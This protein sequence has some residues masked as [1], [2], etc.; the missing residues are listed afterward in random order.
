MKKHSS[1]A[2]VALIQP[3]SNNKS[4]NQHL[5]YPPANKTSH[6]VKM[7]RIKDKEKRSAAIQK[8]AR[9]YN[10]F[11]TSLEVRSALPSLYGFSLW[12]TEHKEELSYSVIK[13]NIKR[14]NLLTEAQEIFIWENLIYQIVEKKSSTVKETLIGLLVANDFLKEV[15]DF[16][17]KNDGY[18]EDIVFTEEQHQRFTAIAHATVVIT[19]ELL[20]AET[21]TSVATIKDQKQQ[22]LLE[23]C[24][25]IQNKIELYKQVIT[26]LKKINTVYDSDCDTRF[27]KALEQQTETVTILADDLLSE[28]GPIV[29]VCTEEEVDKQIRIPPF[30]V[31]VK[32]P[33]QLQS[34][35]HKVKKALK[36]VIEND[37]IPVCN[38]TLEALT[39]LRQSIIYYQKCID[40]FSSK[41]V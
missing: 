20:H 12:L 8:A 31:E 13:R 16:S 39:L 19:K 2:D 7:A 33:L 40:V 4:N 9:M 41:C 28:R 18:F 37:L 22:L 21:S 1:K 29:N 38:T 11:E 10:V 15:I 35:L 30:L 27:N 5:I 32:K 24:I 14:T 3:V 25:L 36:E 23:Q 34:I 26:E 17:Q 6:F